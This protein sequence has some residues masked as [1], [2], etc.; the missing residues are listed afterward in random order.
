MRKLFLITAVLFTAFLLLSAGGCSRK[1]PA[2]TADMDKIADE[3]VQQVKFTDQLSAINL[4]T[5]TK[6]YDLDSNSL[7]KAKVYESTGATAEEVAAFEAKDEKAAEAVRSAASRRVE[8][9]K[10]A[11]QNYQPKEMAKL[12]TPLLVQKGKYVLLVVADDTAPAKDIA[13]RF[14]S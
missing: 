6:L 8:D 9:Q 1:S 11:F 3:I 2:K 4:K 13:D 7:V 14:L 10:A 5:V 12:K